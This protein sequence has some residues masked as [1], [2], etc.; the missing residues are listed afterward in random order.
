MYQFVIDSVVIDS[1]H[2]R[3][4]STISIWLRRYLGKLRHL[5]CLR[6][7]V[8]AKTRQGVGSEGMVHEHSERYRGW[9]P[10][11]GEG[12]GRGDVRILRLIDERVTERVRSLVVFLCFIS[13]NSGFATPEVLSLGSTRRNSATRGKSRSR[14]SPTS[15][16]GSRADRKRGITTCHKFQNYLTRVSARYYKAISFK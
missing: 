12:A 10:G 6:I 5:V 4:I 8:H 15:K 13:G 2:A 3:D 1:H 14:R 7:T 16:S 9:S 11:G